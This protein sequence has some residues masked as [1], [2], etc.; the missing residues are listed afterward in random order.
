MN[1]EETDRSDVWW[2]WVSV[3]VLGLLAY[4]IYDA[5]MS[6]AFDEDEE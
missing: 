3:A 2:F 5:A 6:S 4:Q 1:E